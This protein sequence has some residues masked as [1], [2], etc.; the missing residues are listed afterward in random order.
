MLTSARS[1]KIKW[2]RQAYLHLQ[3][4]KIQIVIEA[5]KDLMEAEDDNTEDV[6][7]GRADVASTTSNGIMIFRLNSEN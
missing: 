4:R 2:C 7:D 3:E 6:G 5:D 1:T